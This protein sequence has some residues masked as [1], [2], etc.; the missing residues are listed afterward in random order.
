MMPNACPPP[1]GFGLQLV[2][3]RNSVIGISWKNTTASDS[4]VTKIATVVSRVI[5]AHAA[6]SPP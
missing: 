3:V 4:S 5:A 6:K 1:A 2:P